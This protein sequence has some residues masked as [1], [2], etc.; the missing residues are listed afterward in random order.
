M[1][2]LEL[3]KNLI[4]TKKK[5]RKIARDIDK[6][7]VST[8]AR[9]GACYWTVERD[10]EEAY[11]SIEKCK[12]LMHKVADKLEPVQCQR[13]HLYETVWESSYSSQGFGSYSY[14]SRRAEMV[15]AEVELLGISVKLKEET[16]YYERT[17]A[18]FFSKGS[19]TVFKIYVQ[20]DKLNRE[21]LKYKPSMSVRDVVKMCWKKGVNPRVYYPLLP[22]GFEEKVG[23]DYFGNDI[24]EKQDE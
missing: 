10:F 15:M 13:Y 22:Y 14:A 21:I 19:H 4:K 1:D 2:K 6:K 20:A 8:D 12:K 16:T 18:P 11:N 7:W 17:G 24:K 3:F 23:L 9:I 5:Y